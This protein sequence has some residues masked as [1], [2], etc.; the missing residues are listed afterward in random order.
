MII[1]F[2]ITCR[3][4]FIFH[5][6]G[7]DVYFYIIFWNIYFFNILQLDIYFYVTSWSCL[8]NIYFSI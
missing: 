6:F 5:Q 1:Y 3:Q 7:M 2:I 4:I 8:E